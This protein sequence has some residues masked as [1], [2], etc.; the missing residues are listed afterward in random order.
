M[1]FKIKL[2]IIGAIGTHLLLINITVVG[3]ARA[4]A[5]EMFRSSLTLRA[6][7]VFIFTVNDLLTVFGK[8]IDIDTR[9]IFITSGCNGR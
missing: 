1:T 6:K 9:Y 3:Q 5:I 7:C 2:Q 8:L 4:Y